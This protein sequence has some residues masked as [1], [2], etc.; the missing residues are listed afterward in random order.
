VGEVW[1]QGE[2]RL[3]RLVSLVAMGDLVS[4]ELARRAAADPVPVEAIESLKQLL[5]KEST[6]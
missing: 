6:T 5:A 3:E 1:S 4:L 2:S